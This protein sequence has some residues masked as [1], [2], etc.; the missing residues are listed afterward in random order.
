MALVVFL[1]SKN[2]KRATSYE[3][4]VD[5]LGTYQAWNP[6]DKVYPDYDVLLRKLDDEGYDLVNVVKLDTEVPGH[7]KGDGSSI[8]L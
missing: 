1:K 5:I 7:P 4:Q 3:S 2:K 6:K 8:H